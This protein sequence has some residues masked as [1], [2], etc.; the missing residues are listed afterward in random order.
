MYLKE[1]T[2]RGFKSFASAT[3]LRF[4]PGITAV[5]G[6]NGSGKSN[7]VDALAWVMGE[8]GAKTLRGSS[9]EDVIFAGTSSRPPLGRAQVSLTID[10]TDHALDIEYSE[11]T[12]SRTIFRS[13][14]SEYAIN[15]SP[16]RLL[17]IQD[18]L[19]DT[20]LGS[21]MHVIVGQGRL[22][23][24]LHADPAG[25][26]AIIE[27]AAG[28]LKHR[29]RKERS[30]RKLKS[31]QDNLARLDDLLSE[32]NR[33]LG[34]LG[35]QARI[36]RRAE[37]IQVTIRDAKARLLADDA[38]QLHAQ[39]EANRAALG[40]IRSRLGTQQRELART[41]LHIEQLEQQSSETNPLITGL[42]DSMHRLSQ[43]DERY[44]ALASLVE[45]RERTT[46]S[47][48]GNRPT[49][50]PE[51]LEARASDLDMQAEKQTHEAQN[52]KVAQEK[53]TEARAS[54]EAQLAAARQT[55]AQL[56]RSTKERE[57]NVARLQQLMTRQETLLDSSAKRTADFKAQQASVAEQLSAVS[58]EIDN[59]KAQAATLETQNSDTDD[60]IGTAL[61]GAQDELQKLRDEQQGIEKT[62]IRLEARA[63]ALK[64]T[65]D[66]RRTRTS[67]ARETRVHLLGSVA[68]FIHVEE[69]WEEAIACAL[70]HFSSAMV[71]GE[72]HDLETALAI[73]REKK[74]EQTAL[75]APWTAYHQASAAK[76]PRDPLQAGAPNGAQTDLRSDL[77]TD[78]QADSRES[79]SGVIRPAASLVSPAQ[80]A[81][82]TSAGIVAAIKRLL[83]GVGVSETWRSAQE[84]MRR[85]HEAANLQQGS[86]EGASVDG[87][88]VW[89]EIVTKDGEIVTAMGVVTTPR[90]APSDLSLVARRQKSLEESAQLSQRLAALTES[91]GQAQERVDS[92]KSQ[93]ATLTALRTE[94][95]AKA[96][97]VATAVKMRDRQVEEYRRRQTHISQSLDSIA[98]EVLAATAKRDELAAALEQARESG[99]DSFSLEDFE[100][101]ESTL[102][103]DLS[104]AREAEMAAKMA[105]AEAS[106][107]QDSLSRQARML[108]DD[109]TH[110]ATQRRDYEARQKRRQRMLK[111]LG[112]LL[113]EISGV[114]SLLATC[115]R[116]VKEKREAAQAQASVHD[117]E[118]T[119]LRHRRNELEPIVERLTAQ[120][121]ENDVNRERYA[122][123]FGQLT[124][125]IS[126]ELGMQMEALIEEYG[127]DKPVPVL[128]GQ[129]EP[130]PV[131]D[132]SPETYQTVPYVR[133]EQEKRLRKAE[134]DVSKLGKINPL[135]MEEFDALQER[136][137][138]L[139][140]QRNDVAQSRDN[141]MRIVKDLDAT[142]E[143]VFKEAFDDV[144]EAF[145]KIFAVLFPG[146]TGRL[147]LENSD[148]L[149]NTG[150][151]VEA[152][153]A[154]KRVK[155]LSLLSGGE[156]SLTA[157]ALLLAV[158]TA[159][160]S[161]FY[162]MD[163]VEAALD[164]INLTRLLEALKQLREHAQLIII[165]HQQRTMAIADALYGITMRSDG[166]TAVI[167]QKMEKT[168][169]ATSAE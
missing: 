136:H 72:V 1:L 54:T 154:G 138:Y 104:S 36:S 38:S 141:L 3:T 34:P 48:E 97:E 160:P 126:D 159:R 112:E 52:L 27:E 62:K 87:S 10:N 121:H 137:S 59:L 74:T 130:I 73:A 105:A 168:A 139:N 133:S 152:S 77:G 57:S 116:Q 106:R 135:A 63:E 12:I 117:E 14:G 69:G 99:D 146:G 80:A 8:Q 122:T 55:L 113:D 82:E 145:E 43:I 84:F 134:A 162:V 60:E 13:G 118:L 67:L 167:S 32:I 65:V 153:P 70:N 85:E 79:G 155:Q 61:A 157:L 140:E 47:Q 108:H 58:A 164:D 88:G 20:G 95:K 147:R 21:Q 78:V 49:A 102:E 45:E 25:H 4:E 149:L 68:T 50:D 71:V 16:V 128:D 100:K 24:I 37:G 156:K 29:K 75:L 28:I 5:V 44:A 33:Q 142:M 119:Q 31:T 123:Q 93:L 110:A 103:K 165:T 148:D 151:L 64:D 26:R 51:I 66:Q 124:Q 111:Q 90:S 98:K 109:A 150:V 101:R 114:R 23:S 42:T 91:I 161:P 76:S 53:A 125:K 127:P 11:V 81:T 144:A 39:R 22:S 2:L 15:G 129:G 94:R 17:D 89:R 166:V 46:R 18:L 120:E 40:E 132:E 9:M 6:P 143:R 83:A 92:L 56:R 86:T 96:R 158:F 7:I 41:K 115:I 169:A 35:R 30:L 107:K 163:E 19:S 131:S